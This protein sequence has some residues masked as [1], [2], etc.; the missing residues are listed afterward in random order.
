[1]KAHHWNEWLKNGHRD[2]VMVG[3]YLGDKQARALVPGVPTCA[4]TLRGFV[5]DVQKL[6]WESKSSES[7]YH[8]VMVRLAVALGRAVLPIGYKKYDGVGE[9]QPLYTT[10]A[11]LVWPTSF[12]L[13]ALERLAFFGPGLNLPR[14]FRFPYLVAS[15]AFS[16]D[17]LGAVLTAANEILDRKAAL[18]AMVGELS[19]FIIH[20]ND[21]VARSIG[22]RVFLCL[23]MPDEKSKEAKITRFPA[24]WDHPRI[25]AGTP[26]PDERA[27][28]GTGKGWADV[29]PNPK[30]LFL[31]SDRLMKLLEQRKL[32][33]EFVE[34]K[35]NDWRI[36]WV[37]PRTT[38][39]VMAQDVASFDH[40][41]LDAERCRKAPLLFFARE[42]P[43]L[44]VFD[45]AFITAFYRA[46]MIGLY[47]AVIPF[48]APLAKRR[49]ASGAAAL[50]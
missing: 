11:W 14:E 37:R 30:G 42:Y 15:V 50:A 18:E 32:K 6:P 26:V 25:E 12:V 44:V 4:G 9:P 34:C 13:K 38:Y 22:N 5:D 33:L 41:E 47:A 43:K 7:C 21:P 49:S 3:A 28:K 46:K 36:W 45:L 23:T 20:R 8:K 35:V 29:I 1:M 39:K 10:E 48:G 2:Y 27:F 40:P 19:D 31:V 24:G 17:N 16:S